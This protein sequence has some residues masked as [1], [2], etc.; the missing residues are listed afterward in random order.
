MNMSYS[1]SQ[2]YEM[3]QPN[4]VPSGPWEVITCDFI[5][6]LPKSVYGGKTYNAIMV[7][8]DRLTK[9]ARFFPINAKFSTADLAT[10]LYGRVYPIH[11]L[12]RQ[13]ISDRGVQFSAQLFQKWCKHIGI[14][15]MMSMAYHPQTDGQTE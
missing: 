9:R 3:A 10:V 15:S 13:I 6:Y 4:P 12:P 11:S 5:M 2:M 7:V 14:K 8:V 1:S